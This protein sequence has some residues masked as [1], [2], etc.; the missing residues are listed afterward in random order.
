MSRQGGVL[1]KSP[2][3]ATVTKIATPQPRV[4]HQSVT[5]ASVD[6]ASEILV[7]G[8]GSGDYSLP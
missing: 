3:M 8:V 4:R 5:G 7:R 1:P 6:E 2:G